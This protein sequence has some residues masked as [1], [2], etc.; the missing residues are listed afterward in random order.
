MAA[1]KKADTSDREIS[2]TRVVNAPRE[3]VYRVWTEPQHIAQWWGPNGFK[4]TVHEM[5]VKPGG[6]WRFIMH[7]P[8]G[9]DYSNRVEYLEVIPNERLVY[10]LGVDQPGV[11]PLFETTVTFED[12][13]GKTR[14]TMHGI[15]SS[16]ELFDQK[17]KQGAAEGGK[18]TMARMVEYA[19]KMS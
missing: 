19:E 6:V 10:T 9:T 11:A 16:R 17:M 14:V 7:G 13:G 2:H 1:A 4:N 5:N 3:L 15:F 18:Q 8:D 12:E